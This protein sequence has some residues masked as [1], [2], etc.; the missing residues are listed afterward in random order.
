[1]RTRLLGTMCFFILCL[2]LFVLPAQA[3]SGRVFGV[4]V[5]ERG[6]PVEEARV[7]ILREISHYRLMTF[8]TVTGH[9]AFNDVPPGI[10]SLCVTQKGVLL[11]EEVVE[12]M[13]PGNRKIDFAV[14]RAMM[15]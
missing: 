13:L 12:F 3:G 5:D 9:Y 10:Y 15:Q 2:F 8:T 7:T 11:G 4:V 1:M 14:E 6:L